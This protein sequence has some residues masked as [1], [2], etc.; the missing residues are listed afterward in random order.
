MD[1]ALAAPVGQSLA[2]IGQQY[3]LMKNPPQV[4]EPV[5]PVPPPPRPRAANEA[6]DEAQARFRSALQRVSGQP[7]SETEPEEV[8]PM[9][10]AF[11]T[12]LQR[13]VAS[14]RADERFLRLRL[15][16]SEANQLLNA[17]DAPMA[18]RRYSPYSPG[19]SLI[20]ETFVNDMEYI[21]LLAV[22]SHS[23]STSMFRS[24]N[25]DVFDDL[26]NERQGIYFTVEG[27]IITYYVYGSNELLL[28]TGNYDEALTLYT[29]RYGRPE[30]IRYLEGI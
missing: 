8:N 26:D 19:S 4:A 1:Y 3:M 14:G 20:G 29:G 22:L 24:T 18:S 21:R 2:S 15:D 6:S 27:A 13:I 5:A 30:E 10:S 16:E 12:A 17:I 25:Q 7:Q 9:Q 28:T 11:D 23:Q